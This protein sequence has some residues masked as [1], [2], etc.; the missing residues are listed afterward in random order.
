MVTDIKFAAS[1]VELNDRAL[2]LAKAFCP[3]PLSIVLPKKAG[4]KI[5]GSVNANLDSFSIRIPNHQI[6]L[7]VLNEVRCPVVL[8]SANPSGQMEAVTADQVKKYFGDKIDIILDGV[9]QIGVASTVVDLCADEVKILRQ[10][11]ITLEEIY[12]ILSD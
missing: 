8:T 9:T 5:D 12:K 11:V 1:Y 3:G 2:K 4:C 6:A 10:G 7:D